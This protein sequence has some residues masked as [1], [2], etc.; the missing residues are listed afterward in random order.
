MELVLINCHEVDTDCSHSAD[1]HTLQIM[2]CFFVNNKILRNSIQ[3][4]LALTHLRVDIEEIEYFAV[5]TV[6]VP[7][8]IVKNWKVELI[9]DWCD[10]FIGIPGESYNI[11]RWYYAS[12]LGLYLMSRELCRR[13]KSNEVCSVCVDPGKLKSDFCFEFENDCAMERYKGRGR[14]GR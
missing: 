4:R 12:K 14:D 8:D 7:V 2:I 3:A 11:W 10:V 1:W 13:Y 9:L 5:I 6:H